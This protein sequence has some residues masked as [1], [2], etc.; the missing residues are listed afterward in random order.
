MSDE[1]PGYDY[2]DGFNEAMEWTIAMLLQSPH[3]LYRSELGVGDGSG[4]FE[5]TS[6]ELA[7]ELS[8]LL[9]QTTPDQTL[10]SLAADGQILDKEILENQVASMLLD[11]RANQTIVNLSQQWLSLNLLP[12]VPREG[13]YEVLTDEIRF[14]MAMEMEKMMVAAF[15]EN[16]TLRELLTADHSFMSEELANY[17]GVTF[18]NQNLDEDGFGRIDLSNEVHYGGLLTQGA[19]LTVHALPNSSSPIHRGV[20]IRERLLCQELPLPPAN[21]DTSPPP[22]DP[23]KSTREKYEVHSVEPACS[24]CHDLI[25][26]L[27]FGL[28][29]YD[30]IGRWRDLDGIHEIDAS[31]V[32]TGIANGDVSFNGAQ[33]M[34][35]KL[36]EQQEVSQCYMQQ[37]Y[38]YGF[39][40]RSL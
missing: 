23:E 19:L 40:T 18:Q 2:E 27:G 21:L 31:G 3:F 8:Y 39:G 14:Q 13:E 37:W 7:T 5:L 32:I 36:A 10:L 12:I 26:P 22:M 28:E 6:W 15:S 1:I 4:H 11:P 38:S 29:H 20:L 16:T 30:G 34:S 9:W 33:N 24:G 35:E 25:D 17:Y